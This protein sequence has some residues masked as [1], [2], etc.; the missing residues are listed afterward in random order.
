MLHVNV[1]SPNEASLFRA[2]FIIQIIPHLARLEELKGQAAGRCGHARF[3]VSGSDAAEQS[4]NKEK[5]KEKAIIG[6]KVENKK[7]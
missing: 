2:N 4:L 5:V 7:W 6:I 3:A 1:G